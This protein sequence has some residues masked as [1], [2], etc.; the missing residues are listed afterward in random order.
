MI[1][2]PATNTCGAHVPRWPG[3]GG[4][5]VAR[6]VAAYELLLG[7]A[8]SEVAGQGRGTRVLDACELL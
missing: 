8:H 4:A 7:A 5:L 1:T 6:A 3:G 2:W